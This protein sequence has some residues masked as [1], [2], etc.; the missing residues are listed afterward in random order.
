MMVFGSDRDGSMQLYLTNTE[1]ELPVRITDENANHSAASFSPDGSCIAYLSDAA[2]FGGRRDLWL[3]E[4]KGGTHRRIT[5]RSDVNEYC[6]LSDSKS[7]VYTMGSVRDELVR[8]DVATYRF[9]KLV[10][11]DTAKSWN[12][13]SPQALTIKGTEAIIYTRQFPDGTDDQIYRVNAD[14]TGNTRIVNSDGRDWLGVKP[15]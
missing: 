14:G 8:V 10:V 15:E 7:I 1:A 9:A 12:E 11:T 4:R 13:R 5:Q 2:N 6:W 3:F